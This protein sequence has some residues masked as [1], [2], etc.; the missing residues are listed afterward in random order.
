M[1]GGG[2]GV[3]VKLLTKVSTEYLHV[4]RDVCVVVQ[5]IF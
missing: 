3:V 2:G 1:G 5:L 4:H